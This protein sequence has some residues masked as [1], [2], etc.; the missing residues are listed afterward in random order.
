MN[1]VI[2]EEPEMSLTITQSSRENEVFWIPIFWEI[3]KRK[4]NGLRKSGCRV[5]TM[6]SWTLI[7][8]R[9]TIIKL[10]FYGGNDADFIV[11]NKIFGWHL[12]SQTT[13]E[14][15]TLHS[16]LPPCWNSTREI[17]WCALSG[18]KMGKVIICYSKWQAEVRG[19]T[20]SPI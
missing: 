20:T 9:M 2:F 15:F 10:C 11:T 14:C 1:T 4:Q 5:L 17:R 18:S 8:F 19:D 3:P 16:H 6:K 13:A 12:C 7:Q